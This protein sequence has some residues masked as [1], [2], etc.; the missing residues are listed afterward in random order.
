M[1]LWITPKLVGADCLKEEKEACVGGAK[2]KSLGHVLDPALCTTWEMKRRV[3]T[4]DGTQSDDDDL[5][6]CS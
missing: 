1:L 5:K 2:L 3:R 4:P 6:L